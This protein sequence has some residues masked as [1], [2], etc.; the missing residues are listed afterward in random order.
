MSRYELLNN[1]DHADF[2]VVTDASASLGDNVMFAVCY[3]F[4]CRQIQAHFPMV[5][6][7]NPSDQTLFPVALFGF[8]NKENLFLSA[9]GWDVPYIPATMRRGPFLIGF[10]EDPSDPLAETKRVVTIDVDH[11]RLSKDMGQAIFT[12]NGGYSDYLESISQL[13]EA[14]YVGTQQNQV[15]MSALQS[16][17]LLQPLAVSA[18]LA[19]GQKVNLDGFLMVDDEALQRLPE[20][21]LISLHQQ[22]LL[23]PIYMM[24]AS[25]SQ[26][27]PLLRKK[28]AK[29]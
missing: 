22:G 20:Q 16:H 10:Q 3:P 29:S 4:E 28:N 15:L 11:P 27:T 17:N 21:S 24:V 2:R 13:L 5:I 6:Y 9:T 7:T 14:I 25:M 1:V 8:E 23:L 12:S 19:N 26:L 18:T